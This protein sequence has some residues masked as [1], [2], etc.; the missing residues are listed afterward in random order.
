[1]PAVPV[2][3]MCQLEGPRWTRIVEVGVRGVAVVKVQPGSCACDA[4]LPVSREGGVGAAL[5]RNA[6]QPQCG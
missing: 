5:T 6:A 2:R 1:M 4:A 3:H